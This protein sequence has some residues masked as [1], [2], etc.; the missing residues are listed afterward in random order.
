[1]QR[2]T[3]DLGDLDG[4]VLVFGG[5]YSNLHATRALKHRTETLGIPPGRVIC[6]GDVVAYGAHP[7]ETVDLIGDWGITV[8]KGNVEDSLATD[9][10]DCGC[11]FTDGSACDVLSAGWYTFARNALSDAARAWMGGLPDSVSFR[12]NAIPAVAVHGAPSVIN[13]FV[14]ASAAD[15]TLA[16]EMDRSGADLLVGG[17]CGLPFHRVLDDGRMWLNA[18]VVGLPANDGTARVW[19]AILT[20][21]DDGLRVAF[22]ALDYDHAAAAA[23]LRASGLP[24]AYAETLSSGLWPNM[25]ILPTAERAHQGRPV[26]PANLDWKP[27]HLRED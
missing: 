2:V 1:M 4:P 24:H 9:A 19:Y 14:F 20:P 26:V 7:L 11:G 10:D 22:H 27:P 21:Q 15:A 16:D 8:V 3:A 17:H 5:P 13:R 6:T 25:D 23:A 12:I 18:G